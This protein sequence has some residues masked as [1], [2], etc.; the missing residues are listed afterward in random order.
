VINLLDNAVAAG[1]PVTV[2]V[3][4]SAAA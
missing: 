1:P 4:A 3:R 2:T